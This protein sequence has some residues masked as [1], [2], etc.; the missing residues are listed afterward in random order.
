[1]I[2]RLMGVTSIEQ[3][4]PEMVDTRNLKDHFASIPKDYLAESAYDP[5]Q[6][7]S[8]F[9]KIIFVLYEHN[10]LFILPYYSLDNLLILIDYSL[11]AD[12]NQTH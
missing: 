9:S 12:T 7:R 5:M 4:K 1:M 10:N 11:Y 3:I 8:H 6:P 2:M